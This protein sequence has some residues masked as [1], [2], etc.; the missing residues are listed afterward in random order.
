MWPRFG[1]AS[2][3]GPGSQSHHAQGPLSLAGIILAAD[4]LREE[5]GGE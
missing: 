3:A 2:G 1:E 4:D 5:L